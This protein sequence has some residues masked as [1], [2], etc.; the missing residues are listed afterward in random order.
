MQEV[1]SSEAHTWSQLWKNANLKE[2]R[3]K[4]MLVFFFTKK[5]F[6]AVAFTWQQQVTWIIHKSTFKDR[7]LN[8][9]L[10]IASTFNSLLLTGARQKFCTLVVPSVPFKHW[11]RSRT[12]FCNAAW[13][14]QI[15]SWRSSEAWRI[16]LMPFIE[17]PSWARKNL[18]SSRQDTHTDPNLC[19]LLLNFWK[20]ICQGIGQGWRPP[21]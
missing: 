20:I 15:E 17:L 16:F 2:A 9:Q 5:L 1:T 18:S 21:A 10:D 13:A 7:S 19:N 8:I 6:T 4:I 11:R 3:I 12:E 14:A